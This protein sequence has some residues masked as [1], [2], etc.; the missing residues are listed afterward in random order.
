MGRGSSEELNETLVSHGA[1]SPASHCVYALKSVSG[2]V[3]VLQVPF[4]KARADSKPGRQTGVEA[5]G[6]GGEAG[7]GGTEGQARGEEFGPRAWRLTSVRGAGLS[8]WEDPPPASRAGSV[9][10]V[11][12]QQAS[13]FP[14]TERK[15]SGRA[16]RVCARRAGPDLRGVRAGRRRSA[17][18]H[19]GAAVLVLG[20]GAPST[21]SSSGSRG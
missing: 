18:W 15:A 2:S 8:A 20:L 19:V 12:C 11:H 16:A 14:K 3:S 4:P 21:R 7:V 9:R 17:S 1:V 10:L 5:K 13:L 6:G